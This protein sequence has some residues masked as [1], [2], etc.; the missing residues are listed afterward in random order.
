MPSCPIRSNV[1]V[2]SDTNITLKPK[3][4]AIRVVV[5]TQ[6][7]VVNPTMTNEKILFFCKW[8]SRAVPINALLTVLGNC[9]H[10]LR[11]CFFL[12]LVARLPRRQ[13]RI[14]VCGT[15]LYM[16][17]RIAAFARWK[18]VWRY[19]LPPINCFVSPT[20]RIKTFFAHQSIITR[21][22]VLLMLF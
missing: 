12:K 19:Y 3:F 20:R 11:L 6:W 7:S 1:A 16:N 5:D 10:R 13:R 17:Y 18:A 9:F 8:S 15:M 21:C 22:L 4:A 2:A 14:R